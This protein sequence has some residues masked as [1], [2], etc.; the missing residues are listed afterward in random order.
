ML[1]KDHNCGKKYC[2]FITKIVVGRIIFT[3]YV[4]IVTSFDNYFV[5]LRLII[6]L[7]VNSLNIKFLIV[8]NY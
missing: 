1:I 2:L 3:L 8:G 7:L 5:V 4:L 6:M